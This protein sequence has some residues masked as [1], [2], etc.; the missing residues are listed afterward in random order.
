MKTTKK[1]SGKSSKSSVAS[2]ARHSDASNASSGAISKMLLILAV[3]VL[4]VIIAAFFATRAFQPKKPVT[5]SPDTPVPVVKLPVYEI[6]IGDVKFLLILSENLGDYL[7]GR[8]PNQTLTTTEKFIKVT[9]ATQNKG[10]NTIG[11]GAWDLGNILD[12]EGRVFN[13]VNG[14]DFLPEKNECGA[15]LKPEFEPTQCSK[16]YEVSKGS[17]GLRVEVMTGGKKGLIDLKID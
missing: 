1:R 11:G 2:K 9:I 6:Q 15:Q 12:S 14:R 4:V 17:K 10:K 3:V 7:V 8:N 13:A 16:I 5:N